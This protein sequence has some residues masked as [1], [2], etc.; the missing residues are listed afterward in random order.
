MIL[1]VAGTVLQKTMGLYEATHLIFYSW[2]IWIGF[3]PLPGGMLAM[4]IFTLNLLMRFLLKSDWT[5]E[6]SG[7]HLTHLGVLVL[8]FGAAYMHFNAREGYVIMGQGATSNTVYAYKNGELD[9][10]PPNKDGNGMNWGEPLVT[11]PFSLTLEEF[12]RVDYAGTRTPKHYYSDMIMTMDDVEF[13]VRVELNKPLYYKGY[14]LY[15]SSFI[16]IGDKKATILQVSE[17][18]AALSP[19]IASILIALG[20]LAHLIINRVRP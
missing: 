16:E 12:V 10:T 4:S 14:N 6:K 9:I 7:I 19:Y 13:P 20:L 18:H 1:V 15:Q 11:L 3:I 5:I 8:M 2:V 17:N